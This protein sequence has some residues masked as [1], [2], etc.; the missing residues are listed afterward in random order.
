MKKT[1][2]LLLL[3]VIA[4]SQDLFSEEVNSF[5]FIKNLKEWDY[6]SNISIGA[7]ILPREIFEDAIS[8]IPVMNYTGKLQ[9]PWN[10]THTHKLST[11]FLSNHISTSFAYNINLDYFKIAPILDFG[12][13]FGF[14]TSDG[15]DVNSR[16]LTF[17]PAI[18]VFRQ[19]EDFYLTGKF[20]LM[21]QT[22]GTFAGGNQLGRTINGY[23][24]FFISLIGEKEFVK[25]Y[26]ISFEFKLNYTKFHNLTWLSFST[27]EQLMPYSEIIIGINL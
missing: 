20:G 11:I 13:W 2:I 5:Y 19:V 14:Y 18:S 16:G 24:G 15:I 27:F 6:Q 9:L 26:V 17:Y 25:D 22:Q 23:T 8:Q 1:F 4:S 7:I 10:I 21:Y 3:I 12:F